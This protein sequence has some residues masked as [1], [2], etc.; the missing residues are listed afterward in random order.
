MRILLKANYTKFDRELD[1]YNLFG[2][3]E[4]TKNENKE[5]Y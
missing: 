2:I 5:D 1:F 4:R 3:D